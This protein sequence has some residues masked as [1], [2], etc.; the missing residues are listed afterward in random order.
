MQRCGAPA[1]KEA[2][3]H[4]NGRLVHQT[5]AD[6]GTPELQA[7]R[8]RLSRGSDPK[9]ASYALGR[10]Y[11][12]RIV[13]QG[14]R[15]AGD[16][17]A[18]L[19]TLAVRPVTIAS[20]LGNLVAGGMLPQALALLADGASEDFAAEAR[21]QYLA[22]RELLTPLEARAVD[23]ICVYQEEGLELAILAGRAKR[24][25]EHLTSGLHKLHRHFEDSDRQ[26][27]AAKQAAD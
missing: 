26:S 23:A 20:M 3:R 25:L 27:K 5:E 10:L 22:A 15:W 8:A 2:A 24:S 21:S 4:P 18:T 17:Y 12:H 19:F 7:R 14:D 11:A 9:L 1:R 16:R 13:L 6:Q